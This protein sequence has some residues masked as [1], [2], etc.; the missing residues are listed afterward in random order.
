MFR[1][2]IRRILLAVLTLF[3]IS[4]VAFGLFFAVPADP[5][6]TMCARGCDQVTKDQI[7]ARLHLD[8]PIYVQYF[9]YM[10]GIFVGR[11][12]GAGDWKRDCPAPCLGFSFR[13]DE[14]VMDI[15][16]RS[17]PITVSIA[18]GAWIFELLIGVTAGVFAALRRG[19]VF[20]KLA[21]SLS[22][23]GAAMPV[24]FFAAILLYVFVF[25]T[26][27]LPF[28]EYVPISKNPLAWAGAFILPWLSLALINA[29]NHSRLGRAQMLE[30]LSEDFI[31]TARA[32]GLRK[33]KVSLR[34][35]LRAAIN[36]I[37][38]M[39]GLSLGGLLGGAV[40][41]ESV[42]GMQGLGMQTVTAARE[43][44]MPLV[45]ATVLI[46][47]VFI[48]VANIVV[49]VAYAALDPRVRLS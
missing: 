22:L 17:L 6:T 42:F 44:N 24:F 9:D 39:A 38:T 20:D 25:G 23:V 47:T 3:A 8:D 19:T 16:K 36:P 27:I 5:A 37:V 7:H 28:P 32:K 46:A 33:S 34:H 13:T 18:I 26:G 15:V 43:L 41:T 21:I 49:D 10:K 45:M 14:P 31:R 48:V 29:A 35:A 2:L 1:F 30:T 4:V 12:Y 11:E 40:I